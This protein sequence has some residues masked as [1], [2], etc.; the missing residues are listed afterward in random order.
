MRALLSALLCLVT[1]GAASAAQIVDIAWSA[2]GRFAHTATLAPGEVLELCG[3]LARGARVQWRY[4]AAAPLA[5]N[6]HVHRGKE[7]VFP[8]RL[9]RAERAQG[10]QSFD[11][12][13]PHCWMW[14]NAGAA[15]VRLEAELQRLAD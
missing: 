14:T 11:A 3:K 13:P 2:E 4:E 6:V 12:E 15:P 8:A 1:T 10:L 5:F 7:L 9:E